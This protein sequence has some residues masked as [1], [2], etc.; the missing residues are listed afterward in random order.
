MVGLVILA[1]LI[2]LVAISL[3]I[4]CYLR[5]DRAQFARL[6]SYAPDE[7][8]EEEILRMF[9][10]QL[11]ENVEVRAIDR[12][13]PLRPL[14][15]VTE[16]LP[17]PVTVDSDGFQGAMKNDLSTWLGLPS[18]EL[19]VHVARR[20]QDTPAVFQDY[21][22]QKLL[23]H[24][25][26]P[27]LVSETLGLVELA[28]VYK[29]ILVEIATSPSL[30]SRKVVL[31]MDPIGCVEKGNVI[32]L[33]ELTFAA[34]SLALHQLFPSEREAV[35]LTEFEIGIDKSTAS[36]PSQRD[37]SR[38]LKTWKAQAR[39]PP[40]GSGEL[41]SKRNSFDWIRTD[42]SP[43][44]R[45]RR[46]AAFCCTRNVADYG[47][48]RAGGGGSCLGCCRACLTCSRRSWVGKVSTR[49]LMSGT[50]V[51]VPGMPGTPA[52]PRNPGYAQ[53]VISHRPKTPATALLDC[54]EDDNEQDL[55]C[56]VSAASAYHVG[57][58]FADGGRHALEEALCTM[59]SLYNSLEVICQSGQG[60]IGVDS[61]SVDAMSA[62]GPV[63]RYLRQDGAIF[64]PSVTMFRAETSDGYRFRREP[65]NVNVVSIA[66][67]NFNPQVSD[68]PVE[69]IG[70]PRS[71]ESGLMN[72]FG[73]MLYAAALSGSSTLVIPDVGCGV[74]KNDPAVV[75]AVLGKALV[76]FSGYFARIAL[77]S[78]V[79]D[80]VF[81][82]AVMQGVAAG[83]NRFVLEGNDDGEED[84]EVPFCCPDAS[85]TAV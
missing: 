54:S 70:D 7:R 59:S 43:A 60:L 6:G 62:K 67:P 63:R 55:V 41:V 48:Y 51:V 85:D 71:Y 80:M 32:R 81:Q 14:K 1:S 31:K 83:G 28:K 82:N 72:T 42:N 11:I 44:D 40:G 34:L 64:S 19:P 26:N 2:V 39:S 27:R 33:P 78:G 3:V 12:G 36:K 53:T 35:K 16:A 57:G 5:R 56:V 13:K 84:E 23:I 30:T 74:F 9:Y 21:G 18:R 79:T 66:L 69:R 50:R 22:S 58:G 49:E 24:T 75:G 47:A 10:H 68:S 52:L 73:A 20:L 8:L 38:V 46:L 65:F 4:A 61:T 17:I 77:C 29:A 37:W 15:S 25:R 76:Q 45:A